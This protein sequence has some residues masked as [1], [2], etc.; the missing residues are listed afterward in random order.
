MVEA[1]GIVLP[2]KLS[3]NRDVIVRNHL[4]YIKDIVKMVKPE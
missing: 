4:S 3:H 1:L 2:K